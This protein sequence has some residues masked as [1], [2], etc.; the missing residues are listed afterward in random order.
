MTTELL[1]PKIELRLGYRDGYF[2]CMVVMNGKIQDFLKRQSKNIA[3]EP[4]LHPLLFEFYNIDEIIQEAQRQFEFLNIEEQ[5]EK[6]SPFRFFLRRV[7]WP[8][9]FTQKPEARESLD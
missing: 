2:N 5:K 6:W 4:F 7:V 8:P 3:E 9:R 1:I